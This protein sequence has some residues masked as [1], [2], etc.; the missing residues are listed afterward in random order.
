[1]IKKK[2]LV[3]TELDNTIQHTSEYPYHLNILISKLTREVNDL[4]ELGYDPVGSIQITYTDRIMKIV[5]VHQTMVKRR[6]FW[7][8]LKFFK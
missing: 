2:Y 5:S 8:F 4:I 6:R 1:M 3:I 7:D